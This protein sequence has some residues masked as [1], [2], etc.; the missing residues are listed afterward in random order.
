MLL[1]RFYF[2]IRID[3]IKAKKFKDEKNKSFDIHFK[4]NF[5]MFLRIFTQNGNSN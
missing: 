3:N 5:V 4:K 1:L 2:R